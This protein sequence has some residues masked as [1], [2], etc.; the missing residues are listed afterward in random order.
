M[1]HIVGKQ[2]TVNAPF[3]RDNFGKNVK[4]VTSIRGVCTFIGP[5][6]LLGIPLQITIDRMPIELNHINDIVNI[7]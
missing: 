5:N 3:L 7:E 6:E 4:G 2:V 1:K